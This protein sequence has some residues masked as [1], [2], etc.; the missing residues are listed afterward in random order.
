MW[1]MNVW[2]LC[3][4]FNAPKTNGV[5]AAIPQFGCFVLHA[6]DV[7][8]ETIFQKCNLDGYFNLLAWG[9]D[10]KRAWQ[11][12]SSYNKQT[13]TC[14]V[15]NLQDEEIKFSLSDHLVRTTLNLDRASLGSVERS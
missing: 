9:V 1:N 14:R 11:L 12:Y 5:L 8:T 15:Q 7:D 2:V 3:T 13:K 4:R 10:I 6:I